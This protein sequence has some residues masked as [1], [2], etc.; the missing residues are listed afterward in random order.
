MVDKRGGVD[1]NMH[2]LRLLDYLTILRKTFLPAGVV[3][4]TVRLGPARQNLQ[5]V[6]GLDGS[7]TKKS[8]LGV[9]GNPA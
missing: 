8:L 7:S 4:S 9:A 5:T 3:V 2:K 6:S 1:Y